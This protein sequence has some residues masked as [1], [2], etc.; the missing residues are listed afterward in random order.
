MGCNSIAFTFCRN[1]IPLCR[2][3]GNIRSWRQLYVD[4]RNNRMVNVSCWLHLVYWWVIGWKF[5]VPRGLHSG[6]QPWLLDIMKLQGWVFLY[7]FKFH[8]SNNSIKKNREFTVL[9]STQIQ[10]QPHYIFSPSSSSSAAVS[11]P[12]IHTYVI[13]LA[14]FVLSSLIKANVNCITNPGRTFSTCDLIVAF[15]FVCGKNKVQIRLS[16]VQCWFN[17]RCWISYCCCRVNTVCELLFCKGVQINRKTEL[18][19]DRGETGIGRFGI[20]TVEMSYET[21]VESRALVFVI[22]KL[23]GNLN[24]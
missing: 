11:Y 18:W 12:Y 10:G 17:L 4:G 15:M 16:V 5:T 7:T 14:A 3:S 24:L 2:E 1:G 9:S 13:S 8:P 19:N 21:V 20:T 22:L 23:C 6:T